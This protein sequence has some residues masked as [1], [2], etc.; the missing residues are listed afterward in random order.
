M[1]SAAKLCK[2]REVPRTDPSYWANGG[3]FRH[4]IL[5]WELVTEET[6]C[7][8]FHLQNQ[9][10][11]AIEGDR[12]RRLA[13]GS[14]PGSDGK[15]TAAAPPAIPDG[16]CV[17]T[18]GLVL[19]IPYSRR[20]RTLPFITPDQI[21]D[22]KPKRSF[23]VGLRVLDSSSMRAGIAGNLY[24]VIFDDNGEPKTSFSDGVFNVDVASEWEYD[25]QLE[26]E[27]DLPFNLVGLVIS[28]DAGDEER[29]SSRVPNPAVA[30]I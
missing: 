30:G 10:V 6:T 12:L 2:V 26:V 9:L 4:P 11:Y 8:A 14:G 5:E 21:V 18:K 13:A 7:N 25:D 3:D 28:F 22:N 15:F 20:M 24:P 19:G 17:L 16:E 1:P 29:N 27:S 23:N